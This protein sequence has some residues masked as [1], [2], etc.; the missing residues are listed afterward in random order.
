MNVGMTLE[1]STRSRSSRC[2]ARSLLLVSG[3]GL[4]LATLGGTER[5]SAEPV[6]N[7]ANA[8][9]VV[10]VKVVS[11]CQIASRS[12][13]GD[14]DVSKALDVSCAKS[15]QVEHG[16]VSTLSASSGSGQAMLTTI[17]F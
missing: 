7:H 10:S 3:L 5:A 13:T 2:T 9:L 4:L 11:P 6:S 12:L 16:A 8:H 1:T 14:L 17:N 15:A